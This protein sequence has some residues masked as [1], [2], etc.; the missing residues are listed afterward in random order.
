MVKD[1]QGGDDT[2]ASFYAGLLVSAFAVAEACTAMTWGTV[3]DRYGRKPVILIGLAGTALSSLV[4]GFAIN[5]W[6]ALGA[7]VIGGL[8]NGNVAVMQTM[9]AEM[10]KKPEWERKWTNQLLTTPRVTDF[11]SARAYA[12]P[13]FM[14][15]LGMI[16]GSA[17]GGFLAQPARYYPSVFPAD[18]LFGI[19]PYLLPNLVAVGLILVAIIQGY[20]FLEETNPRFQSRSRPTEDNDSGP[21]DEYT[22]LQP[23][24]RRK[25][26]I[27]ILSTGHRRPSFISGSMPTMS[28]P[29]FNLRKGSVTTLYE[30]KPVVPTNEPV[31]DH[32]DSDPPIKAFNRNV[33]M[34]TLA[35]VIMCYHQMAFASLLP[36][37]LLDNPQK[38]GSIDLRGG[39][40]Y[41]VHDVGAFM[42]I[43]GVIALVIQATIFPVFVGRVGI[44]K[45]LVS[46]LILCPVSYVIVPFLSL[47]PKSGLA[48][49]V[50]AVLTLQNFFMIIIYPCL[51]IALKNATPSSLVLGKINGLAM[52]ACSGAR[53]IAPP[54]AGIIYSAGGSAT[55]WWSI[56]AVAVLGALELCWI[57]RPKG[58]ADVVVENILRR[59]STVEPLMGH[60]HEEEEG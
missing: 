1:F 12:M 16:I 2:N 58:D 42:S 43:N 14:W 54:L 7:R 9:V 57:A 3:S 32:N 48:V 23:N 37:Y 41:T 47:L 8:L 39:L 29:S 35:L 30:I 50:Y 4:F 11:A 40:G 24:A 28:E 44:W 17:M 19:F 21:I 49:G 31:S 34:W 18:G 6:V 22:P 52:S 45:S 15:S 46:L 27:D 38:P 20:F 5:F 60:L 53:T 59:K 26:A 13:P 10:C 51:L 56:A 25:S 33:I 36:I 55:A